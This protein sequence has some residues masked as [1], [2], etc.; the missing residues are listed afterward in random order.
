MKA[1]NH[2]RKVVTGVSQHRAVGSSQIEAGVTA[3]AVVVLVLA[4]FALTGCGHSIQAV[5]EGDVRFE[6]CMALDARPAVKHR[7]R[8]QCW[9]EWVAHYTFG[10]TRDRVLHAQ[11]RIHQLDGSTSFG[12]ESARAEEPLKAPGPT[13]ALSPP[14]MFDTARSSFVADTSESNQC[15]G[16]CQAARDACSMDCVAGVRGGGVGSCRD[17]CSVGHQSCMGRCL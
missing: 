2:A 15:L 4:T 1:T 10:Q 7:L 9:K 17:N 3:A 16:E 12:P 13:S 8:K 5:Y 14:P 6:H 11:L